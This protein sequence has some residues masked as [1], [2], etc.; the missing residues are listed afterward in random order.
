MSATDIPLKLLARQNIHDIASWLLGRDIVTA[1]ELSI[2]LATQTPRVDLVFQLTLRDSQTCLFHLEFQGQRSKPSMPRRQLNHL[3]RL[4]LQYDWPLILESFV[5]Y[6]EKY[7][8]HDDN[9]H[10]QLAR[11]DGSPTISWH[12]TPVH[13]WQE[14]AEPLLAVDKP[15]IIPLMGLMRIQQPEIT[16]PKMVE[17][18]QTE[19]NLVK[20]QNLFNALLALMGNEEYLA[21]LEKLVDSNDLLLDTPFLRRIRNQTKVEAI[22]R[23]VIVRLNPPVQLYQDIENKISVIKESEKLD[24]LFT[25]ALTTDSIE[26]FTTT[27]SELLIQE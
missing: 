3:S 18:L 23:A 12:Y 16:L 13:L 2:E 27:L 9:G 1:E 10:Y 11:L 20:R 19:P 21:M 15:G 5:L 17:R 14:P 6:I 7:A 24:A 26:V 22:L 25:A 4:S 8:G